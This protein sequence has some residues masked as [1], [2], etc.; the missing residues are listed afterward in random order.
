MRIQIGKLVNTDV[1]VNLSE[2]KPI[3]RII[4]SALNAYHGTAMYRRRFADTEEKKEEQRRKI[5]ESLLD[6]IL[7][8]AIPELE[9]NALLSDKNDVC[10]AVLLEV[11]SRF[12]SFLSDIVDAH[13]LDAYEIIIIPPETLLRKSADPPY[14]V[15]IGNKGG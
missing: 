6:N 2:L 9:S 3:D 7:A 13:E 14:L 5:R 8:V 4:A 12:K 15:Y 1:E 11:P 10:N